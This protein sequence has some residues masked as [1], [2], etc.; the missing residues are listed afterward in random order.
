MD[1][2]KLLEASTRK[3]NHLCP[4]QILGVRIGLKGIAMLGLTAEEIAHKRML[5]IAE[6]DGCFIDGV[7][8]ATNCEFGRRTLRAEDYGKIAATF[9]DTKTE[10]AYR[11]APALDI[12]EKAHAYAPDEPRHYFAQLQAYQIMPDNEL[13]LIQEVRLNQAVAQIISRPGVRVNCDLCSEEIIN[14]REIKQDGMTL[15]RTCAGQG[16]YQFPA[17]SLQPTTKTVCVDV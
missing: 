2:Q 15:C 13:L 9:I 8:A 16:Y 14:Q 1:I 3:H 11:I 12:R 6:T 4:R 7:V 17:F 5:I 10:R